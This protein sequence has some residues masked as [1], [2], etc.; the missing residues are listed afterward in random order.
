[1]KFELILKNRTGREY[2]FSHTG[3]V[4]MNILMQA[5][6]TN[7]TQTE[8]DNLRYYIG[9]DS[10]SIHRHIALSMDK[11]RQLWAICDMFADDTTHTVDIVSNVDNIINTNRCVISVRQLQDSAQLLYNKGR[12]EIYVEVNAEK[13]AN[14]VISNAI[15]M[16]NRKQ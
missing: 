1:M 2:L 11:V 6:L 3:R 12:G 4:N 7:I 16:R 14:A 10:L 9:R 15:A 5:G 8:A 13:V